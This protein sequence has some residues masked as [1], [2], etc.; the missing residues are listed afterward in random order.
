MQSVLLH[1]SE[2]TWLL[3]ALAF[4]L[5]GLWVSVRIYQEKRKKKKLMCPL[6]ANCDKV[7]HSTFGNTFGVPNDILGI[8]YYTFVS[9]LYAGKVAF[10][11]VF[12]GVVVS[13]ALLVLTIVGVL[14]SIYFV[15]L[16]AL[17]IRAWCSLCLVSA[18]ASTALGVSLFWN[19]DWAVIS[20]VGSHKIWW[21][22]IHGI[23]FVL[24]V[25]GAT[26]SDIFFFRFLKDHQISEEEKGTFD[27]LSAIIWVGLA[28]LV[29]SGLMLYLPEQVR[30]NVSPKFLLKVVVVGV[31]VLNGLALNLFVSPRMRQLSFDGA[32]PA[33]A[34]R[35]LAFA[36][37]G[38]S[39]VSWYTAFLL[40]SLR[41]IGT[42]SFEMGLF[43]YGGILLVVVIGSQVFERIVVSGYHAIPSNNLS[44]G[45]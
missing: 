37:G 39:I 5:S 8:L 1:F 33:R 35:R 38:V 17:V 45:S 23:G 24:G 14:F 10:P 26:F 20:F 4:A 42:Y 6:R 2:R 21:T 11:Q 31:I 9:I 22:I 40:G 7:V 29:L 27:T 36:L 12:G 16:Q 18:F 32:K 30:L 25:G 43:G 34:F 13:Y 19:I 44:Q 28:L 41:H 15:A 3:W